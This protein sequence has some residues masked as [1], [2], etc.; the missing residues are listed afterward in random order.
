MSDTGLVWIREDFRIENNAALSY[1]T[2]N[3]QNVIAFFIYN[4]ND[5]DNKREAQKWWLSKSLKSFKEETYNKRTKATAH[6][7][8][9]WRLLKQVKKILIHN[10]KKFLRPAPKLRTRPST[11]KTSYHQ[12]KK[13]VKNHLRL[14]SL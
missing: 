13:L 14:L 10:V 6:E 9:C 1:A 8:Q 7:P 11:S 4:N 2:Q 12:R 5:Y 3:H